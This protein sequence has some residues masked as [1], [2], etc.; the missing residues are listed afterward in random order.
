MWCFIDHVGCFGSRS[1]VPAMQIQAGTEIPLG[2]ALNSFLSI[3]IA[4]IQVF[5]FLEELQVKAE[6]APNPQ[7]QVFEKTAYCAH[8]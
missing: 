5:L 3:C 2:I 7:W 6:N 8:L 4:E 1:K